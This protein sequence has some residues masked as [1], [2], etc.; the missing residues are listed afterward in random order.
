MHR[1]DAILFPVLVTAALSGAPS[2]RGYAA[3]PSPEEMSAAE[4]WT[5]A[6]FRSGA[7]ALP[8][9]F[10][11]G[12]RPSSRLLPAWEVTRPLPA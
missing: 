7:P 10:T 1:L 5:G 3:V 4:K 9:S 6:R 8:F 2:G 12:G 11:Y